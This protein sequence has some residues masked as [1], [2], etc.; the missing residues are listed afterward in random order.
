LPSGVLRLYIDS[1]GGLDLAMRQLL[2]DQLERM[3]PERD[4]ELLT[5]TRNFKRRG[6]FKRVVSDIA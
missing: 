2:A 3:V 4:Y 6:K 1:E 5:G